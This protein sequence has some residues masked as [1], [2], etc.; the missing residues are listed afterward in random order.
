MAQAPIVEV[1]LSASSTMSL[2][3]KAKFDFS[4]AFISHAAESIT[5]VAE[6]DDAKID[7]ADMEI[8]DS[9]T[10]QR[11]AP[12]LFDA[13]NCNGPWLREDFLFLDPRVPDIEQRTFVPTARY[14]GLQD[15]EEGTEHLL[16]MINS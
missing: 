7:N 10:R 4:L 16:R 13:G 15:L 12:D 14:S 8:L 2:S 3:E 9:V 5:V 11:V 6:R 1:S